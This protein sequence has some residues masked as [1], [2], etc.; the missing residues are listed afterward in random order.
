M[1]EDSGIPL[2]PNGSGDE[3]SERGHCSSIRILQV[4]SLLPPLLH[5]ASKMPSGGVH[6][7]K[8]Q[9]VNEHPPKPKSVAALEE[10][11]D[12]R[13]LPPFA[14]LAKAA[15]GPATPGQPVCSSNPVL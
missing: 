14:K 4:G 8:S 12:A 5:R 9:L 7:H 2:V 13:L 15:V 10:K 6:V 1:A 3:H 11:M